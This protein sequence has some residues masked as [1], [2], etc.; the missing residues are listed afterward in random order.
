MPRVLVVGSAN[1]DFTVAAPRLPRPGE[2]VTDG[3]LLVNHGGKGANQAVAARRLGA[4]VRLIGCLGRDPSG[5]AIRA[6]LKA[7]DVGV[8]GLHESATAATGTALIVVDPAGENQITVAPGAN[9][10]LTAAQVAA[11]VTDFTWAEVVVCQLEIP[12]ECV[13]V[14]LR[15]AREHGAITVLNPAPVPSRP[16]DEL[17]PLVDYL[18]PNA[19]E[20]ERLSGLSVAGSGRADRA[21]R[22][23]RDAG[24][25][26]VIVT[27]GEDG[28]R[29]Y[30]DETEAVPAFAVE[31]VDTTAAG[32]AFNGG[33]AVALAER[34]GLRDVLI[35]ASAAAALA[36]TRRGAQASL[37][38]RDD[39]SRL[40]GR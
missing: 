4:D 18:T 38:A 13:V 23:L 19:G 9:R 10:A 15:L 3:T 24:V 35:F 37:P 12:L 30:G 17:W 25:R 26:T 8:E 29:A 5:A 20:A 36:C 32:D 21:A 16:L 31:V 39:V 1:I 6:A 40:I 14:A 7:D 2:T 28:A 11:R 34:R 33:L 22:L 27:L